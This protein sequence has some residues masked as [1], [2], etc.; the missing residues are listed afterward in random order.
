MGHS[1]SWLPWPPGENERGH[2]R[3][4]VWGRGWQCMGT[5][6]SE[7]EVWAEK[8]YVPG[9]ERQGCLTRWC[10]WARGPWL[11]SAHLDTFMD[12]SWQEVFIFSSWVSGVG[13]LVNGL[14]PQGGFPVTSVIWR[15]HSGLLQAPEHPYIYPSLGGH[16]LMLYEVSKSLPQ[17]MV[18]LGEPSHHKAP[19]WHV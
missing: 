3:A 12:L 13:C 2:R 15:A 10:Q 9:K 7:E 14:E 8:G 17:E 18:A 1:P 4:L 11:A 19:S 5:V 6:A 16:T